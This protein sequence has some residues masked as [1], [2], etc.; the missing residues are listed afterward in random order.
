VV[1]RRQGGRAPGR[2]TYWA[3]RSFLLRLYVR[4]DWETAHGGRGDARIAEVVTLHDPDH[5]IPFAIVDDVTGDRLLTGGDFDIESVRVDR[6]G[7]LWFGDEFGP[8]LVHTDRSSKVLEAPIA[9]PDVKSP[10][11]PPDYRRPSSAPRT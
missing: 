7:D 2:D 9:L 11:H 4:A 8:S 5:R 1:F 10:D 3:T 6:H